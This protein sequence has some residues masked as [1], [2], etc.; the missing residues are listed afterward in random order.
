[1]C[2]HGQGQLG[3]LE[4]QTKK[5][6]Q[7]NK[8][9]NIASV[10]SENW[11]HLLWSSEYTSV[12]INWTCALLWFIMDPLGDSSGSVTTRSNSAVVTFTPLPAC[13]GMLLCATWA[14]LHQRTALWLVFADWR[15][16]LM[17]WVWGAYVISQM[18]MCQHS[19]HLCHRLCKG[20]VQHS[21]QLLLSGIVAFPARCGVSVS[22]ECVQ[23][24]SDVHSAV[25]LEVRLA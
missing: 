20:A 22:P 8:T 9:K 16:V 19:A 17:A 4:T 10:L 1:M 7:R 11:G 25:F 23:V 12:L 6:K 18:K 2:Q 13:L 3:P 24:H 5:P 21:A 15:M 14:T